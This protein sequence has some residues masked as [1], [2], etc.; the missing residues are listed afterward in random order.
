VIWNLRYANLPAPAADEESGGRPTPLA[1]P[2]VVP[3]EY[4][5][6]LTAH[7]HTAEQKLRVSEDPRITISTAERKSWTDALLSIAETYRGVVSLIGDLGKPGGTATTTELSDIARELQSRVV[8]LYRAIG[9]ST[10][11]PTADQQA[12]AP[13]FESELRSL[14]S[15]AGR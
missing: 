12:Q 6:R 7:G 15:R 11:K 14:R 5:V 2:L 8:S 9:G 1:G 10:G 13:F 4:T 3:G